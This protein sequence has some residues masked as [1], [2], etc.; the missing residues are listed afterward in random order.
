MNDHVKAAVEELKRHACTAKSGCTEPLHV[1]IRIVVEA[2]ESA[3]DVNHRHLDG[4][5]QGGYAQGVED[6]AK[7]VED[8]DEEF[9]GRG[10]TRGD[11]NK[12]TLGSAVRNVRALLP[13]QDRE[14]G[15]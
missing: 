9:C 14:S 15:G 3:E 8:T 7:A 1:A 13:T 2:L 5:F 6:A 11:D 12:A 4:A 10:Y